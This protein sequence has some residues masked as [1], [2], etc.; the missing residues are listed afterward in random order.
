MTAI[1]LTACEERNFQPWKLLAKHVHAERASEHS[2]RFVGG[3]IW[4]ISVTANLYFYSEPTYI[5][6]ILK[7][8]PKKKRPLTVNALYSG[9]YAPK[10]SQGI[11][12]H[13]AATYDM[14]GCQNYGPLLG[15]YYNTAPNI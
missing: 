1:I 7:P 12:R 9:C 8:P 5:L 14:G 15:P 4:N 13:I 3:D 6:L 10:A 2:Q 11:L